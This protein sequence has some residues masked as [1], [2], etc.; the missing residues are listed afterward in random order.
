MLLNGLGLRKTPTFALEGCTVASAPLV[1]TKVHAPVC[2]CV[3][4]PGDWGW[5]EGK[6]QQTLGARSIWN[7]DPGEGA[8]GAHTQRKLGKDEPVDRGLQ[9]SWDGERSG[10]LCLRVLL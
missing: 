5:G 6:A 3:C 9:S 10:T 7:L 8:S 4:W 2:V 1:L